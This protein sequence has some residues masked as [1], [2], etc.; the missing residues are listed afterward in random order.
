MRALI[1]QHPRSLPIW[2]SVPVWLG[3]FL[4]PTA[5]VLLVITLGRS[6]LPAPPGWLVVALFCL[7]PVAALLLCGTVVLFSKPRGG[8]R[9]GWLVLTVLAMLAQVGVLAGRVGPACKNGSVAT[10]AHGERGS[11]SAIG[12]AQ[13]APRVGQAAGPL[14]RGGVGQTEAIDIQPFPE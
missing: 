7:V 12:T 9:V 6:Q 4:S 8:W 13:P 3:A 14:E 11:G 5:Y 1:P 10:E 2:L